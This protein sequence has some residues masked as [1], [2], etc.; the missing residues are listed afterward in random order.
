MPAPLSHDNGF[1]LI[2]LSIVLVIIGLIVG[3]VL[4]GQSLIQAA[5]VRAQIAQIEQ[6]NTAV[7]TF[8]GKFGYLPGDI[9]ATT[10]VQFGLSASVAARSW[11]GVTY[12]DGDGV[13]MGLVAGETDGGETYLFWSDLAAAALIQES[14]VANI[15]CNISVGFCNVPATTWARERHICLQRRV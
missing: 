1:T 15:N 5:G 12:G 7:N 2:E 13:V 9:P 11:S 3:G 6:Y 10:A 14:Q 8:Y 4:V